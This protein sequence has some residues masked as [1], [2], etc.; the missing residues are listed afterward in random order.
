MVSHSL[1]E[2]GNA[3]Y[4]YQGQR[5]AGAADG[6]NTGERL[7]RVADH[8]QDRSEYFVAWDLLE[9]DLE[10]AGREEISVLAAGR[11]R[12]LED[13]PR[14]TPQQLGMA[15]ERTPRLGVDDR[16]DVGIAPGRIPDAQ[17]LHGPREQ[18]DDTWRDLILYA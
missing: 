1:R 2:T 17:F 9:L 11:Q 4:E 18:L 6:V 8:V 10:C 16:A 14:R 5:I 15:L 7:T 13:R 12:Q 3:Q